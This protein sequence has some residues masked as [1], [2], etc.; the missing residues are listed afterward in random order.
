MTTIVV[1]TSPSE[2]MLVAF[3]ALESIIS[4]AFLFSMVM[5]TF[6]SIERI[7][8]MKLSLSNLTTSGLSILKTDDLMNCS[9]IMI[10]MMDMSRPDIYSILPCPYGCSLS[11]GFS[12]SLKPRR[13]TTD[14]IVSKMLFTASAMMAME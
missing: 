1:K 5:K 8:M 2:S 3:I 6:T 13:V 11:A 12:E 9:P 14:D 7:M 10:T 4:P